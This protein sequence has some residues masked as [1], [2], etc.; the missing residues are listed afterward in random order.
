M[1][2]VGCQSVSQSVSRWVGRSVGRLGGALK[3]INFITCLYR[4]VLEVNHLFHAE[5][6]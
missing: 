2:S 4:T 6:A 1:L 3:I 5:S